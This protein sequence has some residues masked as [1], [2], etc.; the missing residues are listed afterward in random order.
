M[1]KNYQKVEVLNQN[2]RQ[3][4]YRILKNWDFKTKVIGRDIAKFSR[5]E[6]Y[7][8][9]PQAERLKNSQEVELI[10]HRYRQKYCKI[11]NR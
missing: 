4:Y 8:P 7:K 1:L 5:G 3:K 11:F 10:N 9:S 6:I 2:Y